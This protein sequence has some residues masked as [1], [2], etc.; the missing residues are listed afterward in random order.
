MEKTWLHEGIRG[1][2][3]MGIIFFGLTAFW[4]MGRSTPLVW[5]PA[6]AVE[7]LLWGLLLFG[8]RG[9]PAAQQ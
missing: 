3:Y 4:A 1:L 5:G 6:V 7:M 8:F 9:E 2:L